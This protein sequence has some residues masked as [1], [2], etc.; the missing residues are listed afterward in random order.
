MPG[1]L[2]QNEEE[3]MR[4]YREQLDADRA[5]RLSKVLITLDD[6]ASW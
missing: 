2:L 3:A 5:S 6:H 1:F 4:K